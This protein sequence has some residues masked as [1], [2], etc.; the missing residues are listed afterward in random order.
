MEFPYAKEVGDTTLQTQVVR[1]IVKACSNYSLVI[2]KTNL[3]NNVN[4]EHH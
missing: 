3:F 2:S 1:E 4:K